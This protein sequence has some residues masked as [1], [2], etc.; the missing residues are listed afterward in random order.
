[1]RAV[2]PP[3]LPAIVLAAGQSRRMGR[4]KSALPAGG[5]HTFASR[6]AETLEASGLAPIVF[7]TSTDGTAV[8][9]GALGRWRARVAVIENPH[10]ERG[11]LSTLRCGLEHLGVAQPAALVTLIDVPFTTTRT[12]GDLIAAWHADHAPVV[13]P[14][15]G[16]RHG[17]PIVIGTEAIHALANADP[18]THT[19]R[20]VLGLFAGRR[21]E[22]A[23]DEAWRLADIDTTAEHEDALRE[24]MIRAR[25]SDGPDAT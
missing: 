1:M 25:T 20:D 10:A 8:L 9:D 16:V 18:E 13:R 7:V 22:I 15:S 12:I 3:A 24:F 17:H 19:M 4:P 14:S 5:S 23:V 2:P 6:I 21:R 11:Q